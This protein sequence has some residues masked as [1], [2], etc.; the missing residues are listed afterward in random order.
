MRRRF[1][2]IDEDWRDDGTA[3]RRFFILWVCVWTTTFF[4]STFMW[5]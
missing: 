4:H 5:D 2:G 1:L 3:T